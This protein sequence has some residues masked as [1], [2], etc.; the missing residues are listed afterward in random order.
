M[1]VM[2]PNSPRVGE[3]TPKTMLVFI[4]VDAVVYPEELKHI[5]GG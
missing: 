1:G 2:V 4:M 5:F 3:D